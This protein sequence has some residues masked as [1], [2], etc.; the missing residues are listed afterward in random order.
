MRIKKRKKRGGGENRNRRLCVLISQPF[1]REGYRYI[2]GY[3]SKLFI[4]TELR[5]TS[6]LRIL[7]ATEAFN[8]STGKILRIKKKRKATYIEKKTKLII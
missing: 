4:N 2:K 8:N 3:N 1:S 7:D 6:S 5:T